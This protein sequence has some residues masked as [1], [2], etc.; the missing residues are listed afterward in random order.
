MDT[1]LELETCLNRWIIP[2]LP[3]QLPGQVIRKLQNNILFISPLIDNLPLKDGTQATEFF[4]PNS[5]AEQGDYVTFEW[6]KPGER[7][8]DRSKQQPGNPHA[9]KVRVI[10]E[11]EAK[12]LATEV[13]EKI[14]T[15]LREELKKE[16]NQLQQQQV[17]LEQEIEKKVKEKTQEVEEKE[18]ALNQRELEFKRQQE[19]DRQQLHEDRSRLS[20]IHQER[21][22]FLEGLER[23]IQAS[24]DDSEKTR[25]E[26]KELFDA[27][28]PYRLAVPLEVQEQ[29][30]QPS[31]VLP[32]PQSLALQWQTILSKSGLFLPKNIEMSYL[33]A[34][35]SSCYSG[36]LLLLNGPVGVGKTSI[37]KTSAH[38]LGGSSKIIPVRPAWLD[39]SDLLGFFDPLSE[40]F[41]PSPFL[42]A[43][44]DAKI[45]PDRLCLVCLDELNL[46]RIE[47]Y[48]ADLLSALEYSR[49]HLN[50]SS[51]NSDEHRQGL[52]L[53]STSIETQ[54][55]Q[56]AKFL[57]ETIERTNKQDMRLQQIQSLLNDY[58]STFKLSP[59]S[60]LIGTLNSDETTYD[61]SPKVIDRAY[62]I[63]YP[64]ANLANS[65]IATNLGEAQS[66]I[67]SIA[68]LQ[69]EIASVEKFDPKSPEWKLILRWNQKFISAL[70]IPLG[71]RISRDYQVFSAVANL[72]GLSSQD[73]LGHFIFTKLLPRIYFFKNDEKTGLLQQWLQE[74]E[75]TYQPYDPGNIL[76]QLNEQLQDRR[77]ANVRYWTKV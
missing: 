57:H 75:T 37:I 30:I 34:L 18:I 1:P 40:I 60:V 70:G 59:N 41:R 77:R 15:H 73:C 23:S 35:L 32:F 64:P 51:L 21:Q 54:L 71:H 9:V 68:S 38:L 3:K 55:F 33:L 39:S 66:V 56:E 20:L 28:E 25:R 4:A 27:V 50:I 16:L 65:L 72:I 5:V 26:A 44:K 43:L 67:L 45:Q 36:S 11:Q 2:L 6:E 22:D 76:Y 14:A 63:A 31:E 29:P 58:P 53:Y 52:L 62:T 12:V 48:G 7:G 74:I 69:R 19:L 10:S 61:L 17:S 47:N 24:V 49:L 13:Q 42:T 8:I 46:A